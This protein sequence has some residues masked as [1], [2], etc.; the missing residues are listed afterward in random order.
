MSREPHDK[1]GIDARLRSYFR[2]EAA[3]LAP[4][5]AMW[6]RL[7]PQLGAQRRKGL[8]W[9]LPASRRGWLIAAPA[10]AL[11]IAVAAGAYAA[12]GSRDAEL[13]TQA[14]ITVEPTPGNATQPQVASEAAG[15]AA[16]TPEPTV[17]PEV[18][19]AQENQDS[20]GTPQLRVSLG[21]RWAPQTSWAV[22]LGQGTMARLGS[23]GDPLEAIKVGKGLDLVGMALTEPSESPLANVYVHG[24][25]AYVGGMSEGYHTTTNVGV[26]ILDISDPTSPELVGRIP[27][28]SAQFNEPHSHGDAVVTHVESDAFQG[29]IAI[30]GHGVAD[31]YSL[32]EFPMPFG[33]WDVTDPGAPSFL[34]ALSLGHYSWMH[35]TGDLGDKP[36]DAKAVRGNHLYTIYNHDKPRRLNDWFSYDFRLAVVDLSDPRSPLVVADWD[37]P[38][39]AWLYSVSLNQS[40]TRAYVAGIAEPPPPGSAEQPGHVDRFGFARIV[41]YVLD[42]RDP[43][44]VVQ[45]ARDVRPYPGPWIHRPRAVPNADDSLLILADGRWGDARAGCAGWGGLRILDI[46]DLNAFRELSTFAIRQS[47]RCLGGGAEQMYTA[48]DVAIEGNLVYS[49]W[50]RGGLHVVDISDPVNPVAVGE[51][52]S[53]DNQGPWLSDVALYGDYALASAVWGPGLYVVKMR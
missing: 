10:A 12:F 17:Q 6:E 52:R 29:D 11:L 26:R 28:R 40:G 31:T 48:W 47:N 51:F 25:Y 18:L 5:P 49:T 41:M 36:E 8:V 45:I 46:T 20:G 22:D 27:L 37:D 50:L 19:A 24:N 7:A 1:F 2:A 16:S 4:P 34:S 38:D 33:I 15:M 39:E 43:S 9:R 32:S 21:P 30:V 23:E 3:G 35:E 53:P 14:A 42:I 44:A 13:P